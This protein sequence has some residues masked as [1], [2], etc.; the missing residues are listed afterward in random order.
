MFFNEV[1][2]LELR[3]HELNPVVDRFIIIESMESHGSNTRKSEPVL[4]GRWDV[5]L[6]FVDK[7]RYTLLDKLEPSFDGTQSWARENFHR[8]AIMN[9]LTRES[10]SN[11]FVMISDCDEIPR[12]SVI[13]R[14]EN[15]GLRALSQDMFY[16]DVNNFVGCWNGTVIGTFA[17]VCAAGGPQAVRNRRD[18]WPRIENAG[19]HFSYFGGLDRIRNKVSSF[20]HAHEDSCKLF[21]YRKD[22]DVVQDLLS[23]GDIYQR[24]G[25]GRR[26]FRA[27]DDSRLPAYFLANRDHYRFMTEDYLREKLS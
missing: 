19:W 4:P 20:A 16:Y 14:Q 18:S 23:G 13:S 26:E 21:G 7:V 10:S 27:T 5:V 15:V 11:D 2:L 24:P 6:P 1:E 12:P 17:D 25:E 9:S 3:L 22:E 8:N